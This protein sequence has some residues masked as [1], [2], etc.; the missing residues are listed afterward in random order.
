METVGDLIFIGK[1]MFSNGE[2]LVFIGEN[3]QFIWVSFQMDIQLLMEGTKLFFGSRKPSAS[4]TKLFF[5]S[6]KP[7]ESSTKQSESLT[8]LFY[9]FV[10]P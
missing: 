1:F 2:L 10:D 9:G 8:K 4:L 5:G 6:T 3:Q 7:A